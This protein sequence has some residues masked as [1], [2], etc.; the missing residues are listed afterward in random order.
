MSASDKAVY[1]R[2]TRFSEPQSRTIQQML[3]EALDKYTFVRE[4]LEAVDASASEFRVISARKT[5][6]AFLCGRLTTF[7]RG[8]YKL[9]IKEDP[10]ATDLSLAAI[11][12]PDTDGVP[13]QYATGILYFCIL[14][15]HVAVIQS[16]SLKARGLEQHL[17]WL[18]RGQAGIIAS[19]HGFVLSD[20][21]QQVTRE[22]ILKSHV[23]SILLGR[24]LLNDTVEI[25]P[26]ND[27]AKAQ[28]KYKP[29]G[30]MME[31]VKEL[32]NPTHFEH[33]DLENRV[34]EGN[35]EVWIELRYPKRLRNR[36][37]DS[38][39]LL[40]DLA[41]ALRDFDEDQSRLELADG[42]TVVGSQLKISSRIGA[43]IADGLIAETE[44]YEGMCGWV[45]SLIQNGVITD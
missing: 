29:T 34:F 12:P 5:V 3:S 23:K 26:A 32:I 19:D 1:Y 40:D 33:L 7:E 10:D 8:G 2:R 14:D 28:T 39:K 25:A 17:A 6:G 16:P 43:I 42:T 44:L 11:G 35:L 37:E 18:L 9:V 4:R 27:G 20:E 24:P 38:V 30:P 31:F 41:L 36:P 22:R 21:P 13:H 45:E 15:N